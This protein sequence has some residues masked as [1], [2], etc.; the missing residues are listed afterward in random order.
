MGQRVRAIGPE[1]GQWVRAARRVEKAALAPSTTPSRQLTPPRRRGQCIPLAISRNSGNRNDV[2]QLIP[3]LQKIPSV[4]GL[5]GRLRNQPDSL[6]G[7]RGYDHYQYRRW[8]WALGIKL[9]IA[10]RGVRC[11]SGLA[12]H[13]WVVERTIT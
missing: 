3:L 8:A 10:S 9:V 2:T 1:R 6:L 12:I 11:G 13:R 4:A 7:D 5:V